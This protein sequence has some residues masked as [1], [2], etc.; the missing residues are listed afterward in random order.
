MAKKGKKNNKQDYWDEEFE[1]DQPQAEELAS[2]APESETAEPQGPAV[3]NAEDEF[4][5]D[6]LSNLKKAKNKKEK[7]V[8]QKEEEK[9]QQE[10]ETQ[11]GPIIKT[12]K[13]K[14]RERKEREKQ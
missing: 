11:K 12:K 4:G 13:E 1:A 9:K 6:F 10:Q 14:E 5:G 3:A 8:K 2:P 7:K